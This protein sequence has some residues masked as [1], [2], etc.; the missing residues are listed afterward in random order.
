ML[1]EII[2]PFVLPVKKLIFRK[3][4]QDY[5]MLPYP[6][7]PKGCPNYGMRDH[8]PPRVR[9]IDHYL[10]INRPLYLVI[11]EFD[12][13]KQIQRMLILHPNWSDRQARNCL[14]WQKS[15]RNKLKQKVD[16]VMSVLGLDGYT[17]IPEGQGVQMY[18]TCL[19]SGLKLERIRGLKLHRQIAI[20]GY[21]I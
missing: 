12:L 1:P 17:T 5:C 7:H 3:Q 20:V 11:E 15:V 10:D 14:Y 9:L 18:S 6:G 21:K 13:S 4:I 19:L 2:Q 16:L 8:C